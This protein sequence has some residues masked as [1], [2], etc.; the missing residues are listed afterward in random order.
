MPHSITAPF[1][2]PLPAMGHPE[3][4]LFARCS[5]LPSPSSQ[6]ALPRVCGTAGPWCVFGVGGWYPS[7]ASASLW[8]WRVRHVRVDPRVLLPFGCFI[9][10]AAVSSYKVGG[11]QHMCC[12]THIALW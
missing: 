9:V 10:A 12:L 7:S 1:P 5:F 6:A 3:R 11:E 4:R 2:S 8:E